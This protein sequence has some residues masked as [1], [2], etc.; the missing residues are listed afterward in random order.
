[1]R[2]KKKWG[3]GFPIFHLL[4]DSAVLLDQIPMVKNANIFVKRK[5][6][7]FGFDLKR[8]WDEK[9]SNALIYSYNSNFQH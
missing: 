6:F 1:M 4:Y 7:G 8:I 3:W 5:K 9:F 2:W